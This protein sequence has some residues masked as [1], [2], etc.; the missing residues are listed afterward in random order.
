MFGPKDSYTDEEFW[1]ENPYPDSP[2]NDAYD[3]G[4]TS[5]IQEEDGNWYRA[6]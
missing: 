3:I 2:S 1:R 5:Y 4:G 6:D